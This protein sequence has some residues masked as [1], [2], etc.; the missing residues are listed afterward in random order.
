MLKI[1]K[2]EY[3]NVLRNKKKGEFYATILI[4]LNNILKIL[5]VDSD[6]F[7]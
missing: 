5:Y 7:K 3:K 4:I 1:M 2:Q 6:R